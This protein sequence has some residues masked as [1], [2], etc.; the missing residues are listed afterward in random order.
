MKSKSPD[1]KKF[2][3][4]F[5]MTQKIESGIE[6]RD[7]ERAVD[8]LAGP[9]LEKAARLYVIGS[10]VWAGKN[11]FISSPYKGAVDKGISQGATYI[12][13]DQKPPEEY[14]CA[15]V[16]GS[17][18]KEE[19]EEWIDLARQNLKSAGLLVVALENE[20]G[21]K[22]L[23]KRLTALGFDF[24][25]ETKCKSRVFLV[26]NPPSPKDQGIYSLTRREDGLWTKAGVFSWKKRDVGT[27]AF[28]K[29]MLDS[30][31]K[32]W[33]KGADF[34]AGIGDISLHILPLHE[35]IS[36]LTLIEHDSRALDC[37]RKNLESVRG[38]TEFIWADI[39]Q[40]PLP[41]ALDFIVMNPPF[42]VGKDTRTD[43]G[44]SFIEKAA[45]S[46]KKQGELFMVANV[47]LPYEHNLQQMFETIE[48][49]GIQ[50]GFK[51]LRARTPKI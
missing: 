35:A 4:V 14:D 26:T 16:V 43:L 9:T 6:L 28:L 42:H 46:L 33:G 47:H 13:F 21:G 12:P 45:K 41:K 51:V 5:D 17:K 31:V 7:A 10:S 15:V 18:Q 48:M 49:L 50:N 2:I 29:V 44:L 20:Q 34:G 23:D 24:R 11:T 40:D 36:N 1:K 27:S 30:G 19:T 3:K 38:C 37:A 8:A 25:V 22:S 39:P 32:L